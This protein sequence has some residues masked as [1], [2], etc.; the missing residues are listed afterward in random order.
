MDKN[1]DF[2]VEQ[3][4]DTVYRTAYAYLGSKSAA[5]DV[6]SEVLMKYFTLCEKLELNGGEHLKA[7]LIRVTAN[8]CKDILKSAEKKNSPLE[9]HD[10]PQ[11][12]SFNEERMD[13]QKALN[14]LEEKYRVVVYLYY[15]EEYK[16]EEIAKLL[17]LPKGTVL[18][19]L[20]RARKQLRG[21]LK[22]YEEEMSV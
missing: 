18:S 9:D 21:L 1:I 16:T 12:F 2:V 3:Y 17:R 11:D 10:T 22:D 13:V 14:N 20:A 6:V 5:E 15:Y 19:R 7:W 8:R 4:A